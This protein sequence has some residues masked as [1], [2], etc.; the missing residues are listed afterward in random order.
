VATDPAPFLSTIALASVALVAIV[1]GLLIARFVGLDSDQRASREIMD[2]VRGR[3]EAAQRRAQEAHLTRLDWHAGRFF[4]GKVLD[5]VSRGAVE[6]ATVIRLGDD[7]PFTEQELRP[8]VAEVAAEFATARAILGE[9]GSSIDEFNGLDAWDDLWRAMTDLPEIRW[10]GV[11]EHVFDDIKRARIEEQARAERE[12]E[13]A[14]REQRRRDRARQVASP[15]AGVDLSGLEDLFGQVY[16]SSSGIVPAFNPV[17]HVPLSTDYA[18]IRTRQRD[19]LRAADERARQQLEDIAAEFARLQLAHAEIV[20]PDGRLWWGVGILTAYA[21]VGVAIPM[22]LMSR[23]ADDLSQ[24]GWVFWLF[25]AGL[26]ALIVYM[27]VYLAQ[28]TRRRGQFAWPDRALRA[29]YSGEW[30]SLS[31][32]RRP[33]RSSARKSWP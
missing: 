22:W 16:P 5:A 12:Q 1:G 32:R 6:A 28:L 10:G 21:I 3:L 33:W 14:R 23:G 27:I 29:L 18:A 4:R 13:A 25:G 30:R 26:A 31:F 24:V 9:R 11:W 15:L 8:Y 20:K 7:W 17:L 2:E 19:D